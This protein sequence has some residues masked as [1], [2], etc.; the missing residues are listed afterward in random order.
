M[1]SHVHLA[2]DSSDDPV[3]RLAEPRRRPAV[4]A[5]AAAGAARRA[6]RGG[7]TRCATSATAAT[8]CSA[9]RDAARPTATLPHIL[10]AGPP[11]TTPGGHCHYLGAPPAGV[12]GIRA[13]I[14]E[15]AE[16]GVDVIK[17]MASGGNMTSGSRPELAQFSPAELRAAVAEAH[18]HSL[19]ITA[20]A[21]GTPRSPTPSRPA[22]TAIEHATFR[23]PTVSTTTPE[24]LIRATRRGGPSSA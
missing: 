6:R 22:S 11:I 24:E 1:D 21:H 13:A 12:D 5:M 7:V 10:A 23:P 16:R 4:F 8:S 20:H 18:R 19:P 17:I 14:R 9:L 2:F 15:H 3:G